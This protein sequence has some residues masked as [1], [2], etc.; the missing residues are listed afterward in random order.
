MAEGVAEGMAEVAEGVAEE[1]S[2]GSSEWVAR[3]RPVEA[4]PE[5]HE[6]AA[7]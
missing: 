2:L 6:S 4:D 3:R 5:S 1:R 7:E